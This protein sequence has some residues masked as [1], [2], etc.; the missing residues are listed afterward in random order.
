MNASLVQSCTPCDFGLVPSFSRRQASAWN[1]LRRVL[2]DGAGWQSWIAEGLGDFFESPD[3]F[4]I[5]VRQKHTMDPQQ[6][7][8]AFRFDA[9]EITLGRDDDCDIRLAPRSIGKRHAR[10]FTRDGECYIEDLGSGLG[11]FLN[12]SRLP[13]NRPTPVATGDQFAIFPYTFTLELTE[14]WARNAHVDVCGGPVLPLNYRDFL[15]SAPRDHVPMAVQVHPI[16]AAFLLNAGRTFLEDLSARLLA[17]LC[18]GAA[19]RLGLTPADTG[20]FELLIA[21]VLERVN[22]DLRFPLQA[23]LAPTA[24]LPAL[25][26]DAGGISFSF[27]IRVAE[28]T[29]AFR[30]FMTDD[31]VELLAR[32]APSQPPT[33]LPEVSWAFPV[34]AGYAELT[35]AEVA[36]VEPSDI[37]LLEREAAILF[38]NA[39]DRG[40]QLLPEPRN[41]SQAII[42]N[43]FERRCLIESENEAVMEAGAAPDLASLPIR[44]H[45]IVGEKEMTLAEANLLVAGAIVELDR[46]KTDPVRI[47]LNGKIAGAGELVE[48]DGRLGIRILNWRVP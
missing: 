24:S 35:T 25:R 22:R 32:S 23:A 46:T 16:G 6:P 48:V 38:P 11:T 9:P 29:G 45:A 15:T 2:G 47:A 43:Y 37:V 26:G 3:G 31:A 4:E 18:P 1:A 39:P 21:A 36:Q 7:E 40:W 13:P 41:F 27:A 30:L 33:A 14:Q 12:E 8:T 44:M 34:S 17:P 19:A 10:I 42:E 5:R 20:F 28:L